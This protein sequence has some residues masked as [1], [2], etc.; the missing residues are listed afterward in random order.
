MQGPFFSHWY[1]YLEVISY[2]AENQ[3]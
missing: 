2:R 3:S 1:V